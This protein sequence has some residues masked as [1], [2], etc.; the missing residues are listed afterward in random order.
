MLG[1][2]FRY[3][4]NL[5]DCNLL[6]DLQSMHGSYTTWLFGRFSKV[7]VFVHSVGIRL[8][9]AAIATHWLNVRLFIALLHFSVMPSLYYK[10]IQGLL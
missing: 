5:L 4:F 7:D 8:K 9:W 1:G 10:V 2:P 6:L 3:I